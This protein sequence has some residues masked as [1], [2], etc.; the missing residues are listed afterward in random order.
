[1]ATSHCL[2]TWSISHHLTPQEDKAWNEWVAQQGPVFNHTAFAQACRCIGFIPRYAIESDHSRAIFY[3]KSVGPAW[4]KLEWVVFFSEP[5]YPPEISEAAKTI[6]ARALIQLLRLKN[7]A[8]LGTIGSMARFPVPVDN[9]SDLLQIP[10]GTY[11]MDLSKTEEAL[12]A[13]VHSKHRNAIRAGEK[14]NV[15]VGLETDW[16]A[17]YVFLK[18]TLTRAG[19]AC[20][21][22]S[23]L[24]EA[25]QGLHPHGACQLWVAKHQSQWQ[26]AALLLLTPERAYYWFGATTKEPAT[27]AGNLLHWTIIKELKKSGVLVYDLGGARPHLS[28]DSKLYSIQRFKERFGGT[29][30]EFP[31]WKI[32]HGA[33]RSKILQMLFQIKSLLP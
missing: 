7:P 14:Q 20:P 1:M 2:V 21:P 9:S 4:L 24:K 11:Q 31:Q 10:F 5:S 16:H 32:V 26:A 27:G 3:T 22:E 6:H 12:W 17:F 33:F 18:D 29:Y 28:Q 8:T 15:S 13:A 25:A 30:H 23:Y 19:E